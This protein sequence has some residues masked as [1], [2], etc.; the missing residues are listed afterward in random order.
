MKQETI[1]LKE[2]IDNNRLEDFI[3]QEERR[4]VAPADLAELDGA[5][6]RLIKPRQSEGQT[7]RSPY[8]GDSTEK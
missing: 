3:T 8:P 7:S 5:L 1:S 2:A 4:G 6:A